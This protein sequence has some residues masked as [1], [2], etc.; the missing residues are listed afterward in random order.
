VGASSPPLPPPIVLNMPSQS[1]I[2][3]RQ[4]KERFVETQI[5]IQYCLLFGFRLSHLFDTLPNDQ[6]KRV[7]KLVIDSCSC[8][9][10]DRG[11]RTALSRIGGAKPLRACVRGSTY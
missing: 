8:K 6:K 1:G 11:S 3:R 2:S 9:G 7:G 4:A 5:Q 10:K